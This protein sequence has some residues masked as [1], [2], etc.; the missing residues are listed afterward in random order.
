MNRL[1]KLRSLSFKRLPMAAFAGLSDLRQLDGLWIEETDATDDTLQALGNLTGLKTL[2]LGDKY[3]TDRDLA[4]LAPL[5]DLTRLQLDGKSKG[6]H[7]SGFGA[8]SHLTHLKSLDLDSSGFEDEAMAP[9]GKLVS[10]EELDLSRT[11]ITGKGLAS[12]APLSG[13]KKLRLSSCRRLEVSSLEVLTKFPRL[14]S[15]AI[16]NCPTDDS[17]VELLKKLTSLRELYLQPSGL[18]PAAYHA[19]VSSLNCNIDGSRPFL[20]RQQPADGGASASGSANSGTA[21]GFR[22]KETRGRRWSA[23]AGSENEPIRSHPEAKISSG[24]QDAAR[25]VP[26]PGSTDRTW[27]EW[28]VSHISGCTLRTDVDPESVVSYVKELPPIE[29]HITRIGFSRNEPNTDSLLPL[30]SAIVRRLNELPALEAVSFNPVPKPWLAALPALTR[31]KSLSL[32]RADNLGDE[33]LKAIGT[34]TNLTQLRIESDRITDTGLKHLSRLTGLTGLFLSDARNVHGSGLKDL[35]AL[36]K[37]QALSLSNSGLDDAGLAEVA[38]FAN[39]Q[40]L[41]LSQTWIS[42][43]GLAPLAGLAN[44]KQLDLR[45]CRRIDD[46]A[47]GELAKSKHLRSLNLENTR[48]TG[49]HAPELQNWLPNCSITWPVQVRMRMMMQQQG[50]PPKSP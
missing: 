26:P 38:R 36:T 8:L 23:G 48:V 18:S 33:A 45:S 14:E 44:L 10:L 29:F 24:S 16:N 22:R 30:D 11:W 40:D 9:I 37:L 47:I 21:T 12:L 1:T 6:L 31:I 17:V 32:Q 20:N 7:G 28:L 19:L 13:L 39:L 3:F 35:S 46:S 25:F 27:A 49:D 15:L 34:M 50:Q 41:N 2:K 5:H 43:K 4:R 42:P